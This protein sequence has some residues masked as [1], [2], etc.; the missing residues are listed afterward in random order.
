MYA[1]VGVWQMDPGMREAQSGALERIVA[2]VGQLPGVVKGY[3]SDMADP[4]HSHTF[5]VFENRGAAEAFE[6]EVRGNSENQKNS[7]VHN[8]SLDVVEVRATT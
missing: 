1:V 6:A 5:I 7:G 2:G 8:V 3:W 4:Q